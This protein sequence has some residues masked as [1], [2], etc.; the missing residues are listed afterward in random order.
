MLIYLEQEGRG[1]GL[2]NKMKAYQLQDEG[3]DTYEANEKLGSQ[4]R[5]ARLKAQIVDLNGRR[6]DL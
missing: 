2:V 1:I 6:S 4:G 3:A 5:S